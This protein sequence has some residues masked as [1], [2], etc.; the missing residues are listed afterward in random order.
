[1]VSV[2]NLTHVFEDR[3]VLRDIS[4]EVAPGEI[5]AIMGSSGGGKTTLLRCI[6][7]LIEATE[8]Q[9]E[10]DGIDVK[11]SPV[12]ARCRMGMVFQ[13]AALFDFLNVEDNVIFGVVRQRKLKGKEAKA[14]AKESLASVGLADSDATKMPSE[15]SGGMRK[16]VGMARALALN[17][18]VMLYDEPTT[19]LDPITTY[20][21]DTLIHTLRQQFQVTSL[22][23]SHDVTSVVRTADHVAFLHDGQLIFKGSPTDFLQAQDPNIRELIEKS[24]ATEL[25]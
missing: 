2:R 21:I 24:R 25:R 20:A 19:G 18:K 17:P 23:V 8:G 1:M 3:P 13:G 7:G 5:L 14:I 10:V 9:I 15:L 16:R 22:L 11:K 6:S 12:E 4:F